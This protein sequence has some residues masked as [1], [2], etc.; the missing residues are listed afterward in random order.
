M[1]VVTS[2]LLQTLVIKAFLKLDKKI[3]NFQGDWPRIRKIPIVGGTYIPCF[4][5]IT[6]T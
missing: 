6:L 5:K 1:G 2:Y 4:I 3:K